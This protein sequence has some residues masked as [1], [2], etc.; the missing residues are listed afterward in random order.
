M[1]SRLPIFPAS[2]ALCA[3]VLAAAAPGDA[4]GRLWRAGSLHPRDFLPGLEGNPP[5][6]A[7]IAGPSLT[8]F[9]E[10]SAGFAWDGLLDRDREAEG[11]G[12]RT[13]IL[14]ASAEG[15]L[16]ARPLP[17]MA[18]GASWQSALDRNHHLEPRGLD[19]RLGRDYRAMGVAWVQGLLAPPGPRARA[20]P[21]WTSR[22]S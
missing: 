7:L 18:L 8:G 14:A 4:Q 1:L 19:I 21:S 10:A 17:G 9:A 16:W 3:L 15:R 5:D 11:T 2:S 6:T 22:R 12:E 20:R 13:A